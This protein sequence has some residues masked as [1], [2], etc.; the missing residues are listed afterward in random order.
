M[1][2]DCID[3]NKRE[4][5]AFETYPKVCLECYVK[6]HVTEK[7]RIA[8]EVEYKRNKDKPD[9]IWKLKKRYIDKAFKAWKEK[10]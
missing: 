8:Y 10:N 1:G 6:N 7:E 5:F 4:V 3:C 9:K 2:F